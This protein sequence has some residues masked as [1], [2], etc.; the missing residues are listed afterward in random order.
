MCAT[1]RY[2]VRFPTGKVNQRRI[3]SIPWLLYTDMLQCLLAIGAL[4]PSIHYPIIKN[5]TNTNMNNEIEIHFDGGCSP[6]PG[7]KYGSFEIKLENRTMLKASRIELGW[8][9]NNE[10]EFDILI[11]ALKWTVNNLT[12]GGFRAG[13]YSLRLFSDSTI[14]VNR[15]SKRNQRGSGEASMRMASLCRVCLSLIDQFQD[16]EITWNGRAKNVARFG[17]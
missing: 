15:I 2:S 1:G 10:A 5:G 16:C 7:R 17:H 8:G 14:V 4:R 12:S 11:K 6:N 3:Q 9:T 13:A